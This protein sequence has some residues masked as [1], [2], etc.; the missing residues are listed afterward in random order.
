MDYQIAHNI[1]AIDTRNI[2]DSTTLH[3]RKPRKKYI[4]LLEF[5]GASHRRPGFGETRPT[6]T[7]YAKRLLVA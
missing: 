5:R 3:H 7:R 2:E 6:K 4:S 1:I